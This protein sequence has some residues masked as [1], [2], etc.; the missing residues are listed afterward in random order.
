VPVSGAANAPPSPAGSDDDGVAPAG[1]ATRAN[2]EEA[3][4]CAAA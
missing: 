3:S 4:D 1:S 2:S